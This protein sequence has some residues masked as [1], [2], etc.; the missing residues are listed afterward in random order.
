MSCDRGGVQRAGRLDGVRGGRAW[1]WLLASAGRSRREG[2]GLMRARVATVVAVVIGGLVSAVP[3]WA[4]TPPAAITDAVE[5]LRD[6]LV[7]LAPIVIGAA[8]AILVIVWGWKFAK[9]LFSS[10]AR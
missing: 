2:V 3:A 10:S 4:Q 6:Q 7:A 5:D 8:V 9:R 1:A